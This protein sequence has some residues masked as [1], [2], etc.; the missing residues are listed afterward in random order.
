MAKEETKIDRCTSEE[1]KKSEWKFG[2]CEDHYDQ[3]KFGLV[4]K[5][6]KKVS[7]YEK[8]LGHYQAY[9]AKVA[10]KAA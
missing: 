2:F 1:C 4:K 10:R 9:K 5:D 6:G 3:F 8:K 7:D